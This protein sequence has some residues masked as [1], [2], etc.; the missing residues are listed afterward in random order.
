M[1]AQREIIQN[2]VKSLTWIPADRTGTT[3][4]YRLVF[5]AQAE[6]VRTAPTAHGGMIKK[7][8]T[9]GGKTRA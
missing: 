3:G 1:S 6:A 8:E 5:F 4:T 9:H 2:F 7:A